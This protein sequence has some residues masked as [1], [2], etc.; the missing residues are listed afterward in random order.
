MS[1]MRSQNLPFSPLSF[2]DGSGFVLHG[3]LD[4]FNVSSGGGPAPSEK[5]R[6]AHESLQRVIQTLPGAPMLR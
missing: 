1:R 4:G 6:D 5:Y 3:W 2:P